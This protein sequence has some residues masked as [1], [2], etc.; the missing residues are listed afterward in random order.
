MEL[1]AGMVKAVPD[2]RL[3]SWNLVRHVV[4]KHKDHPTIMKKPAWRPSFPSCHG[5][6]EKEMAE[7]MWSIGH[8]WAHV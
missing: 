4:R 8:L 7:K 3:R 6:S 1:L 2:G 5:G